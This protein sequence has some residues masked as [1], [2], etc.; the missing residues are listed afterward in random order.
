[1]YSK[2]QPQIGF[3]RDRIN[4]LVNIRNSCQRSSPVSQMGEHLIGPDGGG[5]H[6]DNSFFQHVNAI[7]SQFVEIE[8]NLNSLENLYS[9]RARILT[10]FL[11]DKNLESNIE[12]ATAQISK[13]LTVLKGKLSQSIQH[14]SSKELSL[15]EK[16]MSKGYLSRLRDLSL[17]FREMQSTYLKNLN[18]AKARAETKYGDGIDDDE[19]EDIDVGFTGQQAAMVM[20]QQLRNERM[21][22]E[23]AALYRQMNEVQALF[24]DLGQLIQDQGTILDRIDKNI[25]EALVEV[26]AGNQELDKAETHQKSKAFYIYLIAMLV[27]I[28]I[29]GTIIIIRKAKKKSSE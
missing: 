7:D 13:Q 24:A 16:N 23:V 9:Q 28:I 18:E 11:D 4:Q 15:I 12:S 14:T 25:D 20:E 5:L 26:R 29:L 21:N 22:E 10:S 19:L 2:N 27:L 17:R 1:M 8:N 6:S 3:Y